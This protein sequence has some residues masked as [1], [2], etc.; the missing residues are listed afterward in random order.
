MARNEVATMLEAYP[1]FLLITGSENP[2]T[3]AEKE[4]KW[5]ETII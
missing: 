5:E 4:K 2:G 3:N 1:K